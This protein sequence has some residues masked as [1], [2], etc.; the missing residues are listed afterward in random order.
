M[1]LRQ[2][3]VLKYVYDYQIKTGGVSPSFD[4]IRQ[5]INYRSKSRIGDILSELERGGYIARHGHRARAIEV[6]WVPA[7]LRPRYR[8]FRFC[9]ETK[10]L[11]PMK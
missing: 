7:D 3:T 5:C 11:V 2:R 6:L 8:I 10:A 9:D 1:S 4:E